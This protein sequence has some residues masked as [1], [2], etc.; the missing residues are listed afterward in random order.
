MLIYIGTILGEYLYSH[1]TKYSL[2]IKNHQQRRW[3]KGYVAG[4]KFSIE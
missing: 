3:P 1:Q 4:I 2:E